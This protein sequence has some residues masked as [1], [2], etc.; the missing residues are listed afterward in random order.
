MAIIFNAANNATVNGTSDPDAIISFGNNDTISGFGG[1]DT[2]LSAGA[3]NLIYGD[4]LVTGGPDSGTG[5]DLLV[6]RRGPDTLWG[7]ASADTLSGG[8]GGDTYS[9]GWV[10][11]ARGFALDTTDF[12]GHNDLIVDFSQAGKDLIDLSGYATLAAPAIFL[13]TNPFTSEVALQVR[14]E[15]QDLTTVVQF[16]APISDD[17]NVPPEMGEIDLAG[18]FDLTVDDFL[19]PLEDRSSGGESRPE[20]VDWNTLVA[21]VLAN[22]EA[23]GQ[24]F[25]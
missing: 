19:P 16:L 21:Q 7:G 8:D 18:T 4:S 22:F 5:S 10:P 15:I 3:E 24:W 25:L 1:D 14:Y 12:A 17:P 11:Q 13:G 23:T 20:E 2:V 6:G 9:F